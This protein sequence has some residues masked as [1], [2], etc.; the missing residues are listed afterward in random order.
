MC[1]QSQDKEQEHQHHHNDLETAV[2]WS[3][4]ASVFF[5]YVG[6]CKNGFSTKFVCQIPV[7]V[8][9]GAFKGAHSLF[10]LIGHLRANTKPQNP[11][12][13]ATSGNL[14][15]G[16]CSLQPAACALIDW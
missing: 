4:C 11:Q 5:K 16:S 3:M 14:D 7:P 13:K 8:G 6:L 2:R 10:Q 15:V 12:A 9:H 1:M